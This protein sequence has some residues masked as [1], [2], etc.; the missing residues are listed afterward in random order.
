MSNLA[1]QGNL[2]IWWRAD[3]ACQQQARGQA[4]FRE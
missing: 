2:P 3:P 1:V 4:S